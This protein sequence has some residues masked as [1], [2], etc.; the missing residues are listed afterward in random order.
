MPELMV[1]RVQLLQVLQNL[2]SNAIKYHSDKPPVIRISATRTKKD[3][4][5]SVADNGLGFGQEFSERIFGLFQRLHNRE[6]EGTGMGL[7]IARRIIERHG[8]EIWAESKEGVGSTF[9]FTLP[10][11]LEVVKPG[12]A[13]P[14]AELTKSV[15]TTRPGRVRAL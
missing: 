6:V 13:G 10:A 3:W 2:I 12:T 7:A 8:G 9:F 1:D 5:F 14:V 11:S 4:Q 15:P